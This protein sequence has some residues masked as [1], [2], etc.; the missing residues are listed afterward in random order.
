MGVGATQKN[1]WKSTP[2]MIVAEGYPVESHFVTTP[3]GYI[4]NIHRI[5]QGI[6]GKKNG[7]IALFAH[8]ILCSSSDFVLLGS[9]NS[10]GYILADE[11]Y[12]V[13]LINMRGNTY[14]RNHTTLNPDTDAEFW[15]FTWHEMGTV[16]IP[17]VIDYILEQTGADGVYFV[18]YS[19]GSTV[20]FVMASIDP[21]YNG[22]VKVHV[23]LAPTVFMSHVRS[24][25][26][27][28]LAA[29][30][31]PIRK[32]SELLGL[33]EFLYSKGIGGFVF[34]K[35]C[36]QSFG[37]SLCKNLL[38][39]LC[40]SNPKQLNDT[41]VSLMMSHAPAG[42]STKQVFHFIQLVKSNEFRQFDLGFDGNLKKY[43]SETPP[44]YDLS[45]ITTPVYIF[46]SANDFLCAYEDI[47]TLHG[48]L[49]DG[50]VKLFMEDEMWNHLDFVFGIEASELVY[51]VIMAKCWLTGSLVLNDSD[52]V[53]RRVQFY[54][55]LL[56][57]DTMRKGQ[58]DDY[59][60]SAEEKTKKN[61]TQKS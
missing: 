35:L 54:K 51:G 9:G 23:G 19:Q 57:L 26:I 28:T 61:A 34:E 7:R 2:E 45:Q 53:D 5:P 41:L 20:F 43:G 55:R 15:D 13:W 1:T 59:L 46:H 6:T 25:L 44:E 10:L 29:G 21:E 58:Y 37:A 42:S 14:S 31:G 3:D 11:G 48:R 50:A 56:E 8:G 38:F 36:S 16:D 39:S 17:T 47:Q 12:D 40:G 33:D 30:F 27:Q 32:L 18:G 52:Y 49:P 24:P 22:K 60:K 4:L